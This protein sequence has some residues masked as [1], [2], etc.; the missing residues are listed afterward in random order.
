MKAPA[1]VTLVS[2]VAVLASGLMALATA[3][4]S[5][6]PTY[7]DGTYFFTGDPTI[8]YFDPAQL[9]NLFSVP[10]GCG[11]TISSNGVQV[12]DWIE[13]GLQAANAIV[14]VISVDITQVSSGYRVDWKEDLGSA[15][16]RGG[17]ATVTLTST[18][19]QGCTINR[20]SSDF[21]DPISQSLSGNA[22][23]LTT[24]DPKDENGQ[25]IFK[26]SWRVECPE[27]SCAP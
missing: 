2:L 8:N 18:S 14:S 19:F 9:P 11:N 16:A 25:K 20:A 15:G 12:K 26:A 6:Q 3:S 4:P 7:V 1:A 22:I 21:P 17:F 23:S 27:V 24:G 5:G 10:S 13:F